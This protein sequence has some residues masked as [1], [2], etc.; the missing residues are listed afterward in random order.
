MTWNLPNILTISRIVLTFVFV[1]LA[2]NAGVV[3]TPPDSLQLALRWVAYMCG[4]VAGV[5][6]F[7]DG[8]I[9]RK[10]NQ[11]SDFGALMDPLAD[12]IFATATMIMLVEF[13]FMSGWMA[14]IILSRE[15]LV[16]GLRTMAV[17]HGRVIRADRW[18][19]CKTALQMSAVAIAG[20]A[21][22]GLFDIREAIF[23]NVH[24]W[25]I[26]W[27]IMLYLVVVVTVGSGIRYFW[28]NRDLI[29]TSNEKSAC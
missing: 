1:L 14:V 28:T 7:A 8:Y 24:L 6:D 2:S 11:T 16:T 21:W 13:Q 9:A 19:K 25:W 22:I 4:I 18:G 23:G 26:L 15:F 3:S 17:H 10:W 29:L 5:T 20:A 12:K 27:Q